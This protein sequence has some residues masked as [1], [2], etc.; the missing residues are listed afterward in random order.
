[1]S[2][3]KPRTI[4]SKSL[5]SYLDATKRESRLIA[6]VERH[7]LTRPAEDR[8]QDILHPSDIVKTEWCA[9]HAYHALRGNYVA[10]GDKPGLRLQSIFDEGH[11]IHHKWQT[12]IQEMG[13]L[14][15]IYECST[16]GRFTGMGTCPS[17][18][19]VGSCNTEYREVTLY[20]D[21]HRIIGHT[22]GWVKGLGEDFLIEIKSIGAGTLRFEA[23][24][25]LSQCDGDLDQA[26]RRI[27]Q[28]FR[29]HML[30]GQVYLHLCHLMAAE[31]KIEKAPEEIVF[32]YELKSNQ[33]Y[34][35]FAVGYDPEYTEEIFDNALDVVWAVDNEKPPACNID[36]VNGCKRCAPFR[37][38]EV[39]K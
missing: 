34:K 25:L 26:W 37:E 14:Y 22:D 33:D 1:M 5:R 29:S 35:E 31:G 19:A 18:W 4:P 28:P 17:E 38:N 24:S 7:I 3:S 15:G 8:R 16:H 30:Q 13:K 12:Y 39:A 20:S 21:K 27:R 11:A 23:P 6:H 2:P 36:P 32:I 10:T 9:L